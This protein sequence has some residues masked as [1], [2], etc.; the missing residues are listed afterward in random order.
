MK[1]YVLDCF[2]EVI[3]KEIR[4]LN[5][6]IKNLSPEN[7]EYLST[8]VLELNNKIDKVNFMY[9][10]LSIINSIDAFKLNNMLTS[11]RANVMEFASRSLVSIATDN[12]DAISLKDYTLDNVLE[13]ELI[14]IDMKVPDG[15]SGFNSFIITNP[16]NAL[17]TVTRIDEKRK[18]WY[19]RNDRK[20]TFLIQ[21]FN[22]YEIHVLF[23]R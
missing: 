15:F 3:Q 23:W 10:G 13:G 11:A 6:K 16:P 14:Q 9:T 2:D 8:S 12:G 7:F 17:T 1:D 4:T 21:R 18:L 5:E 20:I 19:Y 22:L